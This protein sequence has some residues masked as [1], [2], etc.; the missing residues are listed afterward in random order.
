MSQP[1]SS[2]VLPR[3][4]EILH[5]SSGMNEDG[6]GTAHLGRLI[7]A[8]LRRHCARHRLEFRGLHLPPLD[9]G[10]ATD[11]YASCGGS[12]AWLT[13]GHRAGPSA[14]APLVN[15]GGPGYVCGPS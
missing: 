8:S 14:G 2:T 12:R 5:I 3:I 15:L 13:H 11:G 6:G 7:G 9:G 4:D 1:N 10:V